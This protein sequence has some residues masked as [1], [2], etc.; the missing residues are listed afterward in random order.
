MNDNI[1]DKTEEELQDILAKAKDIHDEAEQAVEDKQQD[2]AEK[3]EEREAR[4]HKWC[5]DNIIF[6]PDGYYVLE[7]TAKF[8]SKQIL[9]DNYAQYTLTVPN[10]SGRG[11]P[12][13]I[14]PVDRV[15]NDYRKMS[16]EGVAWLPVPVE[17]VHPLVKIGGKWYVNEYKP[18]T[19]KPKE[20]DVSKWL[21]LVE[22]ICGE[23]ANDVIDHMAFTL[24]YPEKKI[25][26]Q[27]L[28]I[29]PVKR[30]GKSAIFLPL[31]DL[32]GSNAGT[33]SPELLKS[34]WADEL[35]GKK[36]LIMEEIYGFDTRQFNQI[37]TKFSNKDFERLNRK[38]LGTIL[39]ANRYS[40]Y[41]LSNHENVFQ[42]QIDEGKLLTIKGP[43]KFIC[44]D[45]TTDGLPG[46]KS[47]KWY[48]EYWKWKDS[49][50]GQKAML[51]YLMNRDVSN[52]KYDSP[53]VVTQALKDAADAG[54]KGYERFMK[55]MIEDYQEPF[56]KVG[57][58]LRELVKQ[59]RVDYA[60]ISENGVR[61]VL[62]RFGF[63]P[64]KGQ[65]KV[66]GRNETTRYWAQQKFVYD[67][68][69]RNL[70]DLEY[71][72]TQDMEDVMTKR[73]AGNKTYEEINEEI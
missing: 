59:L 27:I 66:N 55:E 54:A 43:G 42:M 28:V 2:I 46:P 5:L 71:M 53:P 65:K 26:W 51:Y 20:N 70:V 49:K 6:L 19:M 12:R 47:N 14:S 11:A 40:M 29:D 48:S 50:K 32:M 52:F 38:T 17:D 72:N 58:K 13:I 9:N 31:I 30:N 21:E 37:K 10:E 41:M 23:H 24:Q 35:V 64:V 16:A 63:V 39:Q 25:I 62:K 8:K 56:D 60:R 68:S 1:E 44:G 22:F 7:R 36:V 73:I 61:E 3:Q 57:V 4:E 15:K 34:G 45:K 18:I 69:A 67:I 33:V